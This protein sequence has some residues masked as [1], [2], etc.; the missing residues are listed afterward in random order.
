M[1]PTTT[2]D[3]AP[4]VPGSRAAGA[5]AARRRAAGRVAAAVLALA[6]AGPAVEPL[7]ADDGR[8][9]RGRERDRIRTE[10][11]ARGDRDRD[12]ARVA[13][14]AGAAG[15]AAS[16]E[17]VVETG[18][19]DE[20]DVAF[21]D[22][23]VMIRFR[24]GM[25]FADLPQDVREKV[26]ELDA[27]PGRDTVLYGLQPGE[28]EPSL[29]DKVRE[30]PDVARWAE[31]NYVGNAPQGNP[32]RFFPRGR[33]A[34]FDPVATASGDSWG[35][36][37]IGVAAVP[38]VD[39]RGVTVAVIDT[40]LDLR[41]PLFAGKVVG[42]WN[43]FDRSAD[44]ADVGDGR[45]NDPAADRD[46]SGNPPAQPLVDEAVGHGTHVAGIVLQAAPQAAIMPIKALDSDGAGQAF[47]LAA[48]VARAV[49]GGADVVNLSLGAEGPSL[50]VNEVV[51]EA[52]AAGVVVVAAAGN[53]G[54]AA[55]PEYPAALDEVIAVGATDRGDRAAGFSSRYAA[56]DLAAPGVRIA[57]AFPRGAQGVNSRY[58]L[59]S[60][61]S[62]AAPWVAGAAALLLDG[63]GDQ[64]PARIAERLVDAAAP[65]VGDATGMGAGR[66][67][68][69]RALSCAAP[70]PAAADPTGAST[71]AGAAP[72]AGPGVG[73][74]KDKG[75]DKP[76]NKGKGGKGGKDGNGRHRR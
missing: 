62:M 59:W 51:D 5:P 66:L 15:S 50:A 45:D 16:C 10:Q 46:D 11:P 22:D 39:G 67:D 65:I 38:C 31:L 27:I 36:E 61:T 28:S 64:P 1:T 56:V 12:R 57:S 23:Q 74:G 32:S 55:M 69:R 4:R 47:Y 19:D 40:G 9:D 34:G 42:A 76:R 68:L 35:D 33:D 44:V 14:A 75:K 37:K 21:C 53:A 2:S 3:A 70:A 52:V 13:A 49:D 29:L 60:G 30:R 20:A 18:D 17:V 71:G 48:A 8:R 73:D 7:L 41:H 24:P 63:D 72:G 25:G 6:F 58:A 43:A 54:P 26:V